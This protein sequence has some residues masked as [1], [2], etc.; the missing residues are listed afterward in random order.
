MSQSKESEGPLTIEQVIE[1]QKRQ[2]SFIEFVDVQ[3][4]DHRMIELEL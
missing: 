3:R 4:R 2:T 1:Q